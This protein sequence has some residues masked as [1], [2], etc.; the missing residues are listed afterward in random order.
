MPAPELSGCYVIP[1]SSLSEFASFAVGKQS[2]GGKAREIYQFHDW[3]VGGVV[4]ATTPIYRAGALDCAFS[5]RIHNLN[6][7]SVAAIIFGAEQELETLSQS[8]KPKSV[9]YLLNP[10]I[11]QSKDV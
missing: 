3:I 5:F 11:T 7:I 10:T 4:S 9:A 8:L 2:G 1:I 6:A